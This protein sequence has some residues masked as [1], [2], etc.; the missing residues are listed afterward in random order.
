MPLI[1]VKV[2]EGLFTEAQ[3]KELVQNLT[4]TMIEVD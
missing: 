3:K 2:I 4:D 1:N